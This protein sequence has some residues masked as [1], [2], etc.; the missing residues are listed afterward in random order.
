MSDELA[1][2]LGRGTGPGEDVGTGGVGAGGLGSGADTD[3]PYAPPVPDAEV[4]T[5]ADPDVTD[6]ADGSDAHPGEGA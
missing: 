1:R 3:G 4:G 2:K 6:D 5:D